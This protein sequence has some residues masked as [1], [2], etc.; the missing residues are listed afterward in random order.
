[1][2]NGYC[3]LDM[4]ESEKWVLFFGYGGEREMG[5]YLFLIFR[6]RE[7]SERWVLFNVVES[8]CRF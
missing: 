6:I 2:R 4:E 1:M 5:I 7:K 8:Q 3:F